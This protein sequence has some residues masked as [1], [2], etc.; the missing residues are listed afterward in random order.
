MQKRIEKLQKIAKDIIQEREKLALEVREGGKQSQEGFDRV[1]RA[2]HR[3]HT[4]L[5][6]M[7]E[8]LIRIAEGLKHDSRS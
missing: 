7:P 2:I 6:A 4:L 8:E 3:I 1:L 5:F